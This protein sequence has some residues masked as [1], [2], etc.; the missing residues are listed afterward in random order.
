MSDSLKMSSATIYDAKRAL[1]ELHGPDKP[2]ANTLRRLNEAAFL[3]ERYSSALVSDW[4]TMREALRLIATDP[5]AD[6]ASRAHARRV[7]G[8]PE[9][10]YS[11]E[12][13]GREAV[14]ADDLRDAIG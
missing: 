11:G 5:G 7:I 2:G 13:D 12:P 6:K 3:G 10:G 8:M 1:A 9:Q 4:E 14:S